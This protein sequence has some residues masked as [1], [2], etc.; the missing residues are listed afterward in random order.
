MFSEDRL[1]ATLSSTPP[2]RVAVFGAGAFGQNHIRV[3]RRLEQDGNPV[4][5]TAV[6]DPFLDKAA[7]QKLDLPPHTQVFSTLESCLA[8]QRA[9]TLSLDAA[10]IC[11][12]TSTHAAVG[13]AALHAGLHILVEKPI[14]P[15][16]HEADALIAL[17][18]SRQ[19]VLQ[20]G[21][22]ERF[23][24]AV[25]AFIPY[26]NQ[27]MFFEAHRLSIFT[28]RSLDVD[29]VLDLMIHDLDV[30]LSFAQSPVREI[31]AVGLPIL[32]AKTDI[33]NVRVE[34]ESGCVANFTA[35]RVSTER[36]RKL[37]FFQPHQYVSIDYARQEILLIETTSPN[38]ITN[39]L[40]IELQAAADPRVDAATA[41]GLIIT[42]PKVTQGEP[43][44]LEI[45]SFLSTIRD[46]AIPVA[47]GRE[48]RAA[49]AVALDI[50][51]AINDHNRRF[52]LNGR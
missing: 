18:D 20:V 42:K 23:N 46:Q 40:Q 47:S 3:Y 35:S 30:V 19:L 51:T 33:A 4:R 1:N 50:N 22:L 5:L 7:I 32:S 12:P 43:L 44:L 9:G 28:P 41:P 11:T 39:P 21:H 45:E 14:A 29:V 17:A 25:R 10:S 49:L 16:L 34:F 2:V 24:P 15:T 48:A 26:L 52:S 36:I 13:S 27:P 31:R 38:Q 6:V 8:A 37:R